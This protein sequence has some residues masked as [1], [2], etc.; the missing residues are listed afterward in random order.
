MKFGFGNPVAP[1]QRVGQNQRMDEQRRTIEAAWEQTTATLGQVVRIKGITNLPIDNPSQVVIN[2]L[3]NNL[4][5]ERAE[6]IEVRG[7]TQISALWRVKSRN[8]G[9]FTAG[10]YSVEIKYGTAT[11]KSVAPL[12]IVRLGGNPDVSRFG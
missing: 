11:A 2:I 8:S 10:A 12:R 6:S 4:P 5:F 1:G 3:F 9:D 7:G